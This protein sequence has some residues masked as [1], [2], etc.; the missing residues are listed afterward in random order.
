MMPRSAT[1]CRT[2]T[3]RP[4][5]DTG[6]RFRYR[7]PVGMPDGDSTYILTVTALRTVGQGQLMTN[8]SHAWRI[9]PPQAFRA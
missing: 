3:R 1:A 2:P 7:L 4:R 8:P 6:S 5:C 9:D